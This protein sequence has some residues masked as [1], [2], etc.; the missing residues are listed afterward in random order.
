MDRTVSSCS[1]RGGASVL[2]LNSED[3]RLIAAGQKSENRRKNSYFEFIR[4]VKIGFQ[5]FAIERIDNIEQ[6]IEVHDF[7][8]TPR[9]NPI[10]RWCALQPKD[11]A[12]SPQDSEIS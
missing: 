7:R 1:I 5:L 12:W 3:N 11:V 10:S 9:Q 4:S 2:A 6:F 8:K